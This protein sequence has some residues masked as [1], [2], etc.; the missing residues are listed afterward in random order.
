MFRSY[1][2]ICLINPKRLA[3]GFFLQKKIGPNVKLEPIFKE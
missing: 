2:K 1:K 3:L